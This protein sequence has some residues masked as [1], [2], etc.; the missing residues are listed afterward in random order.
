M[1]IDRGSAP[2]IQPQPLLLHH[3]ELQTFDH[4]STMLQNLETRAQGFGLAD[5]TVWGRS[6]SGKLPDTGRL[7][8]GLRSHAQ[9]KPPFLWLATIK[10]SRITILE[11]S[12]IASPVKQAS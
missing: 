4:S 3:D 1:I 5:F 7:I 9:P 11:L 8:F 12:L 6:E 2:C 10:I